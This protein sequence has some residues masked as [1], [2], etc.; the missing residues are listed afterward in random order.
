MAQA[1]ELE[2]TY[3]DPAAVRRRCLPS[4]LMAIFWL[5]LNGL[6]LRVATYALL[7]YKVAAKKQH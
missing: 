5:F 2:A 3:L 6:V 7:A 1:R 4:L